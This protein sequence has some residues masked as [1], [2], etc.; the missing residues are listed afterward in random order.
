MFHPKAY[1]LFCWFI[2]FSSFELIFGWNSYLLFFFGVIL[3]LHVTP[4]QLDIEVQPAVV[5]ASLLSSQQDEDDEED[6]DPKFTSEEQKVFA[7]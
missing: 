6:G 3:S 7:L 4:K 1:E 5:N 2:N